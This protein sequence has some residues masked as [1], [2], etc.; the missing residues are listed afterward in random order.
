[1]EKANQAYEDALHDLEELNQ[2]H[3]RELQSQMLQELADYKN[4]IAGLN[5]S[6]EERAKMLGEKYEEL[7]GIYGTAFGKAIDD[8]D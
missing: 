6:D 7:R 8:G 4:F 1:M 3:I 2:N 5:V